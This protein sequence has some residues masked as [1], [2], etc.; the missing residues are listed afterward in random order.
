MVSKKSKRQD[1]LQRK[2]NKKSVTVSDATSIKRHDAQKVLL[3][4]DR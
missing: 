3:V 4:S 1:V 2:K